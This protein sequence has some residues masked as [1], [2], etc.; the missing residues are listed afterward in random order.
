MD[1]I[2]TLSFGFSESIAVL[3]ALMATF[4]LLVEVD[5]YVGAIDFDLSIMMMMSFVLVAVKLNHGLQ[6]QPLAVSVGA[7][8]KG[9]GE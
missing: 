5:K 8:P 3:D 2:L 9:A 4:S 7:T 1:S 6:Q